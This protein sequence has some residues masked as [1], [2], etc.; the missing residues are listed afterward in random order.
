VIDSQSKHNNFALPS[1]DLLTKSFVEAVKGV[2]S[3]INVNIHSIRPIQGKEQSMEKSQ[4]FFSIPQIR[5]PKLPGLY[6]FL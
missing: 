5:A 1:K 6:P 3:D 2:N 4:G